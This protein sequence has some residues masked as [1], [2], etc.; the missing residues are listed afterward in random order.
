MSDVPLSYQSPGAEQL[1]PPQATKGALRVIF[2]IVMMDLFGFGIIIP[3]LPFYVPGYNAGTV[4]QTLKVTLLFSI[5]SICQ[6]IGAPV[7]G[8]MSDRFGRR[9]VLALSQW[10]SALGY[11]LLGLAT[12][13]QF[14]FTPGMTLLLVYVSRI[15]DG[16]TGGNISTAQAYV[17]DVTTPETRA[18]GMAMLGAAFGVGFVLGPMT[19]GILGHFSTSLPAYAAMVMAAGAGI[20]SWLRLPESRVRA[21]VE[22]EVWLHPGRFAPVLRKP[23]LVQLLAISFFTMAAFVMMESTSAL[24]FDAVFGWSKLQIGLYFCYLGVVIVGVQGG[25]ARRLS[26]KASEWPIATAGLL[27]VA[28]GMFLYVGSGHRRVTAPLAAG[29]LVLLFAGGAANATGRSL[30][31]PTFSSLLSK[32]SDP[33]EQGMVFGL[34]HGLMS[35]ARVAGPLVAAPAYNFFHHTGQFLTAGV[36][37]VVLGGWTALLR[38]RAG[39]PP[40]REGLAVPPT[41]GEPHGVRT[42]PA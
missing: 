19:G 35:L 14:H 20:F 1:L 41:A 37:A 16:F 31:Q 39:T 2:F 27:L 25:L 22:D 10:G 15:L 28:I 18:R 40:A 26:G 4:T 12:Q 3:L 23:V 6:F 24:F 34:Y 17:S 38:R 21:P 36:M 30:Q 33:D 9:P 5:Y 29:A 7:L 42:E 8:L 13:P 11:L 32:F